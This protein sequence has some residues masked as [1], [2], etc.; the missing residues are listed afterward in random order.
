MKK[1]LQTLGVDYLLVNSTNE[2]LVEYS[3]LEENA[4]YDLTG[5]SGS[6]G[7]ALVTKD[8]IYLFVD[9]RYH[10]QADNEVKKGITVVKLQIGQSQDEEIRKLISPDKTLGIVA[11]K[12]SQARLEGFKG[13][14]IKLL[15]QDPINNFTKKHILTEQ[16]CKPKVFKSE[17]AI[18][19]SNLEEVSY[20]TG[21]RDFS[22][23]FTSKV[24]SKLVI[25]NGDM[26]LFTDNK[27][28]ETYLSL[29]EGEL[30]VD[31]NSISAWD[32]S[33]IK[34]PVHQT[35]PVKLM[36]AV[37]TN[38]EI[39]EYKKAF[40][41][42]DKAVM[43]IRDYIESNKNLSEY[44]IALRLKEEFIKGGAKILSFKS[45]VAIN[46]NSALAH[47]SKSSKNIK[48]KEGDLVL[49]DCGAYYETGLATDITRVFVKGE[50]N[51]L[52]KRVYTTVLK[53]F[54]NCYN[55][56][57][58]TGYEID[59]LA[60]K[61]L[62]NA[63]DGFTFSHGLGHGIGINVHEAPPALNKSEIAKTEIKDNMCF[64]IEPGLYNP[65]HFG[66]R[67]ENSCY[68]KDGKIHSFVKM[69]YEGKLI[70][71]SLLTEKEQEWLKEFKIL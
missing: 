38:E 8:N 12:V 9:G 28:C 30:L 13:Y 11:K 27:A 45:I 31:K 50:P 2:Y 19:I 4:R 1:L 34:N 64:T 10:I 49:I 32:Y 68:K 15:E 24:W 51:E 16:V 21:M 41:R 52:Q 43:A 44:D 65:E 40:E 66:I 63:V 53:A 36:K 69:G 57:L 14:K 26:I 35:S 23:D 42:T 6:T 59:S 46:Q 17:Q 39:E 62:D 25:N 37:K 3:S 29:F 20:L 5:F 70:D 47:Y 33:L 54:L 58:K 22:E 60:H 56:N 71:Y 7:D 48:L 67:L 61:I 18:F 55:S